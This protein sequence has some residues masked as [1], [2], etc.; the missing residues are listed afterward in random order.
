MWNYLDSISLDAE[1]VEVEQ[2]WETET[3]PGA[4]AQ[5]SFNF[6]SVLDSGKDPPCR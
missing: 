3:N 4:T 5:K 1:I 6:L 2:I